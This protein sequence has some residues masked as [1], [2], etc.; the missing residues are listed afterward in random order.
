MMAI[1]L[2]CTSWVGYADN[3][4]HIYCRVSE[5][6][7]D[8]LEETCLTGDYCVPL[9]DSLFYTPTKEAAFSIARKD[10]YRGG[11]EQ[12]RSD[13]AYYIEHGV[14]RFWSLH[15]ICSEVHKKF[16]G[17]KLYGF[18]KSHEDF[19]RQYHKETEKGIYEPQDFVVLKY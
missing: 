8:S 19:C 3:A 2:Y 10:N 9:G 12:I 17:M 1:Q 15:Q 16:P 11:E 6:S 13:V 18:F 7:E 14:S 5:H 4:E